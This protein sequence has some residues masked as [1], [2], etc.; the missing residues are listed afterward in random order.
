[1]LTPMSLQTIL[2]LS[3]V[4]IA[5]AILH[6]YVGWRLIHR[7]PLQ[8][9]GRR[10]AWAAVVLLGVTQPAALIGRNVVGPSPLTDGVVHIT[11]VLLGF[12]V[13]TFLLLLGRDLL[14]WTTRALDR[15]HGKLRRKPR[16]VPEDISRRHAIL[17]GLNLGVVG[18][19]AAGTVYGYA[20]ARR[21]ATVVDVEVPIRDLS[22]ALDGF[23]I[24]QI[25]DIHIGPT[26]KGGW[27]RGVVEKVNALD[28]D[29]VA[30]TGDLVD[31]S[32]AYLGADVAPLGELKGKHGAFFV[33]GN[34]E[35]FSGA[36]PWIAEVRRLGLDVLLNEHRVLT[37]EG[38]GGQGRVLVAGVT[39][40]HAERRMPEHKCD[41]VKAA[42]GAPSTDVRL[43]LAH[44][45]GTLSAAREVRCGPEQR[46]FDLMLSGH[47]HGG[48][49][50]P[51]NL[52][53]SLAH[54]VNAGLAPFDT[55]GGRLW[56]YVN[57]GTGYW[58]P[59][60]R[61]GVPAEITRLTLHRA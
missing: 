41:P 5:T 1:M 10:R 60:Q 11:Y 36:E 12:V 29:L 55:S 16:L 21:L 27:L 23:T 2:F 33:T 40:W 32:V 49:F 6:G 48:Q 17:H 43:L 28:A 7:A 18:A 53:V 54:P 8:R 57:Q 35:Y 24:A 30:V 52:F 56:V 15:A 19:S 38:T 45:P 25:S 34:H 4:L 50:V 58:G 9:Q 26:L 31:G 39:D 47:T 46:A 22:P 20:E 3:V 51:W 61:L 37:H 14:W 59:P 44:Q 13:L 42:E